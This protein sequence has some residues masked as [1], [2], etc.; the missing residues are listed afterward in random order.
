MTDDLLP[1]Y[2]GARR[3]D[4]RRWVSDFGVRL[5]V[6]EW[7]AIDSPPLLL[8]HGGFDFA[9]TFD[10]FAPLLA[11][12]GWT[13]DCRWTG[14]GAASAWA[15]VTT[16]AVGGGSASRCCGSAVSDRGGRNGR[17][18]DCRGSACRCSARSVS[19]TSRWAGGHCLKTSSRG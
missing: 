7:G 2:P 16:P 18:R 8:A 19:R 5:A 11:G 10:V 14:W 17:W 1:T 3:P 15:G 12:G 4:R 13:R 6:S 9:G